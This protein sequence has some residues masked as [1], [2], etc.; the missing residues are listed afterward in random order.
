ME[1]DMSF[2]CDLLSILSIF[3]IV[4]VQ[5]LIPRQSDLQESKKRMGEMEAELQRAN[6]KVCNTGHLLS[7]LSIK[8]SGTS[9]LE[10]A[11][12]ACSLCKV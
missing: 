10:S 4:N 11:V 6:N 2:Q 5:C 8:V 3:Q 1:V 7:Q 9:G 12:F